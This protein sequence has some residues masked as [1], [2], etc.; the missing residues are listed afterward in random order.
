MLQI[1]SGG[2]TPWQQLYL[3]VGKVEIV[4]HFHR[5]RATAAA[6]EV[7]DAVLTATVWHVV[8]C[9]HLL[10]CRITLEGKQV[11]DWGWVTVTGTIYTLG[12]VNYK[13]E[14]LRVHLT[15]MS[16]KL[17]V[18]GLLLSVLRISTLCR[19][20][21]LTFTSWMCLGIYGHLMLLLYNKT[22]LWPSI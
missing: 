16:L 1:L 20:I 9:K 6:T 5:Q 17:S 18:L 10:T 13:V 3:A 11:G 4:A 7:H 12:K 2:Q 22:A 21:A 8:H 15:T 14:L 19:L